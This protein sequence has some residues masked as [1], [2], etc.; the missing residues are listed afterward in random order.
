[1]LM[2][3]KI[4]LLM[5]G[6]FKPKK[7]RNNRKRLSNRLMLSNSLRLIAFF[8]LIFSEGVIISHNFYIILQHIGF[9]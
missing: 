9:L 8:G 7:D 3:P 2:I 4:Y 6:V 5:T 1:M